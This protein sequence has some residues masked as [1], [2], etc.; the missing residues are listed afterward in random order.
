MS[1]PTGTP[2]ERSMISTRI[3]ASHLAFSTSLTRYFGAKFTLH[4]RCGLCSHSTH[5]GSRHPKLLQDHN[6]GSAAIMSS[7]QCWYVQNTSTAPPPFDAAD[8]ME[9]QEHRTRG[10][11]DGFYSIDGA[12]KATHTMVCT[13][14][15]STKQSCTA[16]ASPLARHAL[17]AGYRVRALIPLLALPD[18]EV[19][20]M[21]GW[22][23]RR[24]TVA[25]AIMP[26]HQLEVAMLDRRSGVLGRRQRADGLRGGVLDERQRQRRIYAPR[27]RS[28]KLDQPRP[29]VL[30]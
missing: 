11:A 18:A 29:D 22:S 9:S 4:R 25:Q 21:P 23:N 1:S 3:G 16:T 7:V 14:S 13:R 10:F 30:L 26:E 6:T 15:Q 20:G 17:H 28:R 24:G 2:V 12:L 27:E 8:C 19:M 5:W